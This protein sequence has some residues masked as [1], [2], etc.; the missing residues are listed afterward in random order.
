MKK[1]AICMSLLLGMMISG[2]ESTEDSTEKTMW[3]CTCARTCDGDV[4]QV[5]QNFCAGS[6]A[7][8]DAVNKSSAQSC[9]QSSLGA[10]QAAL[11][12]CLCH[13]TTETC[14]T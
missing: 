13:T 2:C 4:E 5:N 11:C 12:E 10:C 1:L 6:S 8:N 3:A 7:T 14:G 9:I